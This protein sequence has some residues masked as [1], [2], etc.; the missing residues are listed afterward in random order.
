MLERL[1]ITCK[2]TC[3]K[4]KLGVVTVQLL[5]KDVFGLHC[6]H[7]RTNLFRLFAE[8]TRL[9]CCRSFHR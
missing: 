2:N 6:K 7:V 4:N 8:E 5:I 1:C 3:G 9:F